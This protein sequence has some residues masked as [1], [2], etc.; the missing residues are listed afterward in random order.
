L[1]TGVVNWCCQLVLSYWLSSNVVI[2]RWHLALASG[3]VLFFVIWV[4]T[5]VVTWVVI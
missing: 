5:C 3:V 2:W 1:S 4:V